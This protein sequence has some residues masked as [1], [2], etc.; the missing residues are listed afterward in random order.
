MAGKGGSKVAKAYLEYRSIHAA[1]ALLMRLAILQGWSV[2]HYHEAEVTV[3]KR[4]DCGQAQ[5][6][7]IYW[8]GFGAP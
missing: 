6:A 5:G 4:R 8:E 3:Y 2:Q 7:S 1:H